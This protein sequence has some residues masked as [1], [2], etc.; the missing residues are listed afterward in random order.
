MIERTPVETVAETEERTYLETHPWLTFHVDLNRADYRLWLLLGEATS[1]TQHLERALLRPEVAADL[2]QVYLVKGAL[3]TTA[4]EG[5]T[6]TEEEAAAVVADEL[7]L[8][9]SL[10]YLGQEVKNIIAAFNVIR[11]TIFDAD[12]DEDLST[13]LTVGRICE[14]N[15][16][17]LNG[18]ELDEDVVPGRIREHS[19]VV[20]KYRG[21]PAQD[22]EYLLERLCDWLSSSAFE[23]PNDNPQLHWPLTL[24]KACVAHLYL[25]WIHPFGDGNGRT[26]RLLELHILLSAG[27]PVPAGQLLSNHY[28]RTRE[29]YY[30]QLA[31]SSRTQN[32]LGFTLYGVEG[33]VD[34]VRA[35]LDRIWGM[36]YLDR[37]EQYV[38]QVFG[39]ISSD[40]Q[41]RR[42]RLIKDISSHSIQ[43]TGTRALP[44]REPIPRSALRR[45]SPE[46]ALMYANTT[47][48]TLNRDIRELE[49]MG[50][51]GREPSGFVPD[52]TWCSA[53]C[54]R[55]HGQG[56]SIRSLSSRL[57][58][59]KSG[60]VQNQ[61]SCDAAF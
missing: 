20:G 37:W 7:T 40:A 22:C 35:Q 56:A 61:R 38:Y 16:L 19:V 2:L 44:A 39:E 27:F 26:A 24:I 14:Y 33:Y 3:A 32:P 43:V 6:L 21:A 53:L 58:S 30:R 41:H 36:Q 50:L 31:E 10:A 55:P 17:V 47:D 57:P 1:K 5:N 11:G 15:R 59:S 49:E 29:R 54:R 13:D 9:P 52:R 12:D 45:L 4:I 51:L 60:D 18:L 42:L 23:A 48:R 8:P 28:N 46:L 25:A 34:E